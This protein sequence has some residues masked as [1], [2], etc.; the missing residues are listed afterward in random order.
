MRDSAAY[1][2]MQQICV[3]DEL[4]RIGGGRAAVDFPR[5][6]HLLQFS[7]AQQGNPVRHHHGLFLIVGHKHKGNADFPL[8]R[9]QLHLH[10]AAQVRVQGGQRLIQQ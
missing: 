3:S 7:H 8:Q 10:L 2:G 6:C 1:L 9:L 4:S 5:R